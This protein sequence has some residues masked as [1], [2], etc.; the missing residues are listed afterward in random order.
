[1]SVVR[2]VVGPTTDARIPAL[3][4]RRDH[5]T[6]FAKDV[7]RHGHCHLLLAARRRFRCLSRSKRVWLTAGGA[8]RARSNIMPDA[9]TRRRA[10]RAGVEISEQ[11]ALAP[12]QP[13]APAAAL[14][15][16]PPCS[17]RT[18]DWL[19]PDGFSVKF[20]LAS[21]LLSNCLLLCCGGE[22]AWGGDPAA[23]ATFRAVG[24]TPELLVAAAFAA[25]FLVSAL[26][27]CVPGSEPRERYASLTAYGA[28]LPSGGTSSYLTAERP[29]VAAH[30]TT[31]TN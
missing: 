13:A 2:R 14:A 28:F 27:V 17:C 9:T 30:S 1:M 29:L 24:H 8:P 21:Y 5:V 31:R 19:T 12:A 6:F 26:D 10:A 7:A 20:G 11:A 25:I 15:A 22:T 18:P 3:G 16:L 4:Y 23:R